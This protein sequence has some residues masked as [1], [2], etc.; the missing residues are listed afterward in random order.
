MQQLA[1][2]LRSA[3]AC[4]RLAAGIEVAL[5]HICRSAVPQ[6]VFYVVMTS[7]ARK[8]GAKQFRR[9]SKL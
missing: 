8:I 9:I 7:T 6:S 1:P 4:G 2:F 5:S 3:G